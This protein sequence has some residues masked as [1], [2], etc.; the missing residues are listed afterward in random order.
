MNSIGIALMTLTEV[1]DFF[2]NGF[3]DISIFEVDS[4]VLFFAAYMANV[5]L[6][7]F[8]LSTIRG[9]HDMEFYYKCAQ[10]YWVDLKY[11]V[12]NFDD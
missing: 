9:E 3:E 11:W 2:S 12:L 1:G 4:A 8:N 7:G 5:W 6:I 10:N